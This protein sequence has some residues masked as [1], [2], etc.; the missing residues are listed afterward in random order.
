MASMPGGGVRT[1]SVGRSRGTAR[2]VVAVVC[3]RSW[4]RVWRCGASTGGQGDLFDQQAEEFLTFR[5][6]GRRCAPH[7][8]EVRRQP[9]HLLAFL[10]GDSKAL[11]ALGRGIGLC[12]FLE[13][14][15]FLM[16]PALQGAGYQTVVRIDRLIVVFCPPGLIVGTCQWELPLAVPLR[17]VLRK[18]RQDLQGQVEGGWR[19]G[20]EPM[21]CA[22]GG[23]RPGRHTP[24]DAPLAVMPAPALACVDG[25]SPPVPC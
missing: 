3:Q 23:D 2:S 20:G 13:L 11:R 1:R 8:R 5:L 6:R 17:G 10:R 4:R 25:V 7:R 14:V 22:G 9:Q 18:R 21:R 24:T 15:E 16:P 12:E 19:Q